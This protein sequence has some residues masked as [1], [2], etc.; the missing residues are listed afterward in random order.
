[1]AAF[2]AL[3]ETAAA[4]QQQQQQQ[5]EGSAGA[6]A[7]LG[8]SWGEHL[9]LAVA[10]RC[11]EILA[12]M[13]TPLPE[14]LRRLAAW[15]AQTGDTQHRWAEAAAHYGPRIEAFEARHGPLQA[16]AVA[17]A[18]P[19][20]PAGGDDAAAPGGGSSPALLDAGADAALAQLLL[21]AAP[22]QAGS[23]EPAAAAAEGSSGGSSS[24]GS[25]GGSMLPLLFRAYKKLVLW[26]AVLLAE[27]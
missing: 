5:Q 8:A 10:R 11:R 4:Q 19:A 14:D 21:Q 13:P 1:M 26:D 16:A 2:R 12:A 17:A 9:R 27:D 20:Q 18:A 22:R 3:Y 7:G 23:Q 25:S 6:G 15:E 24:G